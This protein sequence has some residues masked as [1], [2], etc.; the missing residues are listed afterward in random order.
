MASLPPTLLGCFNTGDYLVRWR[1]GQDLRTLGSG[2]AGSKNVSRVVGPV[3]FGVTLLKRDMLG[4]G[5]IALL[6]ASTGWDGRLPTACLVILVKPS[7]PATTGPCNSGFVA[8]KGLA[9]LLRG[10]AGV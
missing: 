3:G 7:P 8:A 5:A 2:S 10:A 6:G 9:T 4:A 1:T